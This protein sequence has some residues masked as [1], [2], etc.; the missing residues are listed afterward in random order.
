[1]ADAQQE[2]TDRVPYTEDV[3]VERP[4]SKVPDPER[5]FEKAT[6]FLDDT[7]YHK[8][9][10]FFDI[11]YDDRRDQSL[12]EK[13]GL[14]QEWA[15]QKA[16]SNDPVDTL[17]EINA[18][19]KRLGLQMVGKELVTKLHRYIRLSMDRDRLEKEMKLAIA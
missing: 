4:R 19:K 8:T 2:Q 6:S 12:F 1:M 16:K 14:I 3:P 18:L 13:I 10:E 11:A 5:V 15:K 17:S 7:S 9:A